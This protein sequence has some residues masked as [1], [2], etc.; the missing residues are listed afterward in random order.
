MP[1]ADPRHAL[2]TAPSFVE[3]EAALLDLLAARTCAGRT[4]LVLVPSGNVGVRLTT[5]L[6]GRG[7]DEPPPMWTAER[8][9][10]RLGGGLPYFDFRPI[11]FSGARINARRK[12]NV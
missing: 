11:K 6:R 2:I 4:P 1:D 7:V 10:R 5:L 9:I 8:L 12:R 3:L